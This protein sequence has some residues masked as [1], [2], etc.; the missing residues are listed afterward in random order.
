MYGHQPI[1]LNI[2]TPLQYWRLTAQQVCVRVQNIV[3]GSYLHTT[4]NHQTTVDEARGILQARCTLLTSPDVTYP[5]GGSW[6][7][8]IFVMSDGVCRAPPI[9]RSMNA[10]LYSWADHVGVYIL[11]SPTTIFNSMVSGVVRR[12]P[13][14]AQCA[15]ELSTILAHTAGLSVR[16]PFPGDFMR[17]PGVA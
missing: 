16:P 4:G 6:H 9:P 15:A 11:T 7:A 2:F 5:S 17:H 10:V 1:S 13:V 8:P 12:L 3:C 14:G